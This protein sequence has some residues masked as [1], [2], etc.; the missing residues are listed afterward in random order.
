V[1]GLR[2]SPVLTSD[3]VCSTPTQFCNSQRF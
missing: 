2:V 1:S 3:A